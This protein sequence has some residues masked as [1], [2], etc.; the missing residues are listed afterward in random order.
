M[1]RPL[2]SRRD[3]LRGTLVGAG[4]VTLALPPL[5][6]MLDSRGAFADGMPEEPIFG[7]FFWA[8]GL[9]W[10]AKHGSEQAMAG[11]PDLWTPAQTGPGYG[12]TTV[13]GLGGGL[14]HCCR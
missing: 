4:A 5:E 6:A 14:D 7:L 8:N 1:K 9:P 13:G 11:Y 3:F 12:R 10:N 2:L